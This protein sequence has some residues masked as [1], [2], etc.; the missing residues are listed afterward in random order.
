VAE[1]HTWSQAAARQVE[2]Y[3]RVLASSPGVSSRSSR[4]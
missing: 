4:S 2:V 1:G 3:R